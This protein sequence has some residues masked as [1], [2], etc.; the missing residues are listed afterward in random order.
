[1]CIYTFYL[2]NNIIETLI[3]I[4]LNNLQYLNIIINRLLKI[5]N[6]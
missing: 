3:F 2:K 1:M 4:D 6:F 5:I